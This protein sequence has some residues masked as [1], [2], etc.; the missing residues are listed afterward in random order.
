MINSDLKQPHECLLCDRP[1]YWWSV[2][3]YCNHFPYLSLKLP[4]KGDCSSS[5]IWNTLSQCSG[6][7]KSLA[8]D[9][10]GALFLFSC[11]LQLFLF[12]QNYCFAP[13]TSTPQ[14][15]PLIHIYSTDATD[16]D[17]VSNCLLFSF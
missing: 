5:Q 6:R 4:D 7:Y 1:C 10:A 3:A 15:I 11:C 9:W 17:K 16:I 13:P 12:C 14:H 8:S 2:C